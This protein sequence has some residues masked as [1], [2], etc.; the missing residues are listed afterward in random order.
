MVVGVEGRGATQTEI[1]SVYR[2]NLSKLVRTAT[3]IVGDTDQ[4]AEVVQEAFAQAVR[5]RETFRRE[6]ALD[7][8]LWRI[9]VN[10]ALNARRDAATHVVGANWEST[11][12][13]GSGES[14]ELVDVVRALIAQ[15]PEHERL[16]L[17]LRYYA[18]LDYDT[19]AETLEISSGTVGATLTAARARIRGLM[20]EVRQ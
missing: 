10:T 2:T 5:R 13:N 4:G 17:F 3:A 12:E 6:S 15:L 14:G 8:W 1:E 16:V 9:V 11:T 19:I 20:Q 18:D 7:S